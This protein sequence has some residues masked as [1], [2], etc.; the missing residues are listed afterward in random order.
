MR[1]ALLNQDMAVETAHLMDCEN[2]NAA[3]ATCCHRQNLAFSNVCTHNTLTVALEAIECDI[4]CCNVALQR[5]SREI[6]LASFR[7]KQTVLNQLILDRAIRAHLAGRCIAAM[8]AHEGIGKFIIELAFDLLL[9]QACRDRVV[10][11]KQG[12]GI[13]GDA[14]PDI[15]TQ[16]AVDVHFT[17]NGYPA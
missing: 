10:N 15:L 12:D 11:I 16:G 5:A 6:R 1:I 14:C 7:L 3:E 9:E 13:L 17:G 2:A 4:R 8:E